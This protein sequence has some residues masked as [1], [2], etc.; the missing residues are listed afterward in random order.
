MKAIQGN[1]ICSARMAIQ[2]NP[3]LLNL[4]RATAG[5]GRRA[6]GDAAS[7]KA[8]QLGMKLVLILACFPWVC[9]LIV[10][11]CLQLVCEDRA[12]CKSAAACM[13]SAF[14]SS[15]C[16]LPIRMSSSFS[17]LPTQSPAHLSV[18]I[19][20][21]ISRASVSSL[22]Q[23]LAVLT[24]ADISR[25]TCVL[26]INANSFHLHSFPLS[27]LVALFASQSVPYFACA[28]SSPTDMQ[29]AFSC[30]AAQFLPTIA[31]HESSCSQVTSSHPNSLASHCP[32]S[33]PFSP[34]RNP[35]PLPPFFRP[36]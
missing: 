30:V 23:E 4:I 31:P 26:C 14:K 9:I 10:M 20:D 36:S 11:A 16:S 7:K 2:G 24:A 21:P 28:S 35:S 13:A 19:V 17:Q 22:H 27:S 32:L 5:L 18:I 12:L 1:A 3:I 34:V 15:G 29:H 6:L 8:F 33:T 25:R